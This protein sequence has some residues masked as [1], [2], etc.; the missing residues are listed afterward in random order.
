APLEDQDGGAE[1]RVVRQV[2]QGGVGLHQGVRGGGDADAHASRQRQELLAV[3]PGV[4]GHAPKLALLEQVVLVAEGGD[5]AQ[6][7]AGYGERAPSVEGGQ[8]RGH[9]A[10]GRCEEDGGVQRLGRRVGGGPR[11]RRAQLQGQAPS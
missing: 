6:V 10:A 7:D 11:R 3:P 1:Y 8:G 4:G 5:V 2:A 9:Q